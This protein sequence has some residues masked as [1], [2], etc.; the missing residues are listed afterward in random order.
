MCYFNIN[1]NFK[2]IGIDAM[3]AYLHANGWSEHLVAN[4]WIKDADIKA[5]RVNVEWGGRDLV[6]AYNSCRYYVVKSLLL[7][8]LRRKFSEF[9][10]NPDNGQFFIAWA[11]PKTEIEGVFSG[12][13]FKFVVR[14]FDTE[15]VIKES[16]NADIYAV[17]GFPKSIETPKQFLRLF[18][19]SLQYYRH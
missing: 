16:V 4:N 8:Q 14:F 6:S 19:T 10:I 9:T 12:R 13:G 2:H 11:T 17:C 3:K 15:H 18:A 5:N 7:K 1:P